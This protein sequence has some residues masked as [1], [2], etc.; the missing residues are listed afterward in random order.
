MARDQGDWVTQGTCGNPNVQI[1]CFR[2]KNINL[3]AKPLVKNPPQ[4]QEPQI[5]QGDTKG[6]PNLLS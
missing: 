2:V 6:V 3:K 5:N 4:K 1:P